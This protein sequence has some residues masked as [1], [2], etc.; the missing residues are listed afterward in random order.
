[1]LTCSHCGEPIT[2]AEVRARPGKQFRDD[3]SHPLVKR[4]LAAR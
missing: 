3:P 2:D 4:A 1:V